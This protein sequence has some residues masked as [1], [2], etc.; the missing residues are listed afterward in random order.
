MGVAAAAESEASRQ[1]S[2]TTGS[3]SG[4]STSSPATFSVAP[5]L[6]ATRMPR[7]AFVVQLSSACTFPAF[8]TSSLAS[9]KPLEAMSGT[10][11]RAAQVS[12]KPL[13]SLQ[14]EP[15]R[16]RLSS[17]TPFSADAASAFSALA[18][19][20]L[21]SSCAAAMRSAVATASAVSALTY[22]IVPPLDLVLSRRR[23]F[24]FCEASRAAICLSRTSRELSTSSAQAKSC[25]SMGTC[26][27]IIGRIWPVLP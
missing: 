12:E 18:M 26:R 8:S 24:D 25:F 20:A 27:R 16:A 13:S 23:R 21:T 15:S 17:V 1:K 2:T 14:P 22:S 4:S 9:P 3:P 11:R 19:P 10:L 7:L 6:A 5:P